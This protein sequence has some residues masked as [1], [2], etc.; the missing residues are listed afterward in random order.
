M[1]LPTKKGSTLFIVKSAT[2]PACYRPG[3]FA[4]ELDAENALAL[5][6][7]KRVDHPSGTVFVKD[8]TFSRSICRVVEK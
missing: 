7:Y 1:A 4:T 3:E 5:A 6:G 8:G 2:A